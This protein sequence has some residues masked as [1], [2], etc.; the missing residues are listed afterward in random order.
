MSIS[1]KV[2]AD[3]DND[4]L[5]ASNS[6]ILPLVIIKIWVKTMIKDAFTITRGSFEIF[7]ACSTIVYIALD[8]YFG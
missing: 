4:I 2:V 8:R 3:F 1:N 7:E 6:L 5:V